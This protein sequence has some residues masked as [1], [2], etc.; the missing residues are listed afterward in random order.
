MKK[1]IEFKPV[2]IKIIMMLSLI[3]L[4]LPQAIYMGKSMKPLFAV[5]LTVLTAVI[6]FFAWNMIPLTEESLY[7]PLYVLVITE[8]IICVIF[9]FSGMGGLMG[10][11]MSDYSR[12]N[13]ILS[14]LVKYPWPVT[15]NENYNVSVLNYYIAYFVPGAAVGKIFGQDFHV[16]EIA[17]LI[18]TIIGFTFGLFLV[19]A[20]TKVCKLRTI[21]IFL[22]WAGLDCI[23]FTI[24]DGSLFYGTS[25]LEHWASIAKDYGNGHIANYM[26][27]ATGINWSIQHYVP[28]LIIVFLILLMIKLGTYKLSILLVSSLLF[29]SPL[30][31]VGILP[32]ALVILIYEKG[33]LSKFISLPDLLSIPCV[34]LPAV[35]YFLSMN[36]ESA[37]G[38]ESIFRGLD[39]LLQNWTIFILFVVLEFGLIGVL[40]LSSLKEAPVLD[41]LLCITSLITMTLSLFIDYGTC[42]DFSM[43]STVFSWLILYSFAPAIF[44]TGE[45]LHKKY[46]IFYMIG[47]SVTSSTEYARMIQGVLLH[48]TDVIRAEGNTISGWGM[49]YQYVGSPDSFFFSK[50]C[51]ENID[52]QSYKEGLE[53]TRDN[54][55]L[56]RDEMWTIYYYED[57]LYFLEDEADQSAKVSVIK[58]D[59]DGN[60]NVEEYWLKDTVPSYGTLNEIKGLGKYVIGGYD[61]NSIQITL[62]DEDKNL[63]LEWTLEEMT[64]WVEDNQWD[65]EFEVSDLTDVNWKNGILNNGSVVLCANM[66]ISNF[67]LKDKKFCW[68]SGNSKIID[69]DC[70]GTYMHLYLE[71]P[72]QSLLSEDEGFWIE[73]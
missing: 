41:K 52:L 10:Q 14:D 62:S 28:A 21:W 51:R 47:A 54:Y 53:E 43:R 49:Q 38:R 9:I 56:H 72:I 3:Y 73:E 61:W 40:I 4:L 39:W 20:V 35:M 5:P 22:C 32:F 6:P 46:L 65:Y 2:V 57:V 34:A 1:R 18:W 30:V 8:V 70:D 7:I 67:L 33:R 29:W 19:F 24:V 45:K 36:L 23:G 48:G 69:V 55:I 71:T 37:G 31:A 27:I 12:S 44:E 42:H 50:L 26:S 13:A 64:D 25:H 16:A 68:S 66:T 59:I 11:Q 15:Y 63:T 17:V 58:K 60:G